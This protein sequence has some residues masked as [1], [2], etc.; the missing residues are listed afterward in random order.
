MAKIQDYSFNTL[1]YLIS[2]NKLKHIRCYDLGENLLVSFSLENIDD[3]IAKIKIFENKLKSGI[4]TFKC[5]T[6]DNATNEFCYN[7]TKSVSYDEIDNSKPFAEKVFEHDIE[8]EIRRKIDF[9]NR[10]SE[11]EKRQKEISQKEKMLNGISG[12][13]AS[14]LERVGL[15][16]IEKYKPLFMPNEQQ[17]FEQSE[18][19]F[20]E[21][22]ETI[23]GFEENRK[24]D[25]LFTI[26]EQNK[27]VE[28][29]KNNEMY[30]TTVRNMIKN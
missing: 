14:I 11:L 22:T 20:V 19:N 13:A 25:E 5:K 16:I 24:I 6:S 30:L 23:N 26:D 4:Y 29:L 27:L 8:K 7:V 2:E 28:L 17:N 21:E 1:Y 12:Q 18:N 10:E 15:I 9:E 3:L